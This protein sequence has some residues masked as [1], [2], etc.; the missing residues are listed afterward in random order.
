MPQPTRVPGETELYLDLDWPT[1]SALLL[2]QRKRVLARLVPSDLRAL[3]QLLQLAEWQLEGV[4]GEATHWPVTVG[5]GL[6][7]YHGVSVTA[8][9]SQ[10]LRRVLGQAADVLDSGV[11]SL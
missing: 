10:A 11:G 6:I 9:Q 1:Q 2:D 7:T 4:M 3:A 5:D 8:V